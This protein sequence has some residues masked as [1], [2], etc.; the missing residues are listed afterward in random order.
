[1][2][3]QTKYFG[4]ISIEDKEIICFE[5]G[6]PGFLEEKE[7]IFLPL[8][9]GSIYYVM[10]SV[11]TAELAFIVTDPFVFFK[12][13]DFTLDDA[14]VDQLAIQKPTDVK[15]WTILTL[16]DPFE[17]T[18]ANLQGPIIIHSKNRQAKQVILN[19]PSYTT[20][21]RLFTNPAAVKG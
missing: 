12:S 8:T 1:M 7:F 11:R 15:V 14:T 21:H 10:Q 16:H 18:T 19:N 4:E 2:K 9:D 20:K 3:L 5:N 17:N 6:I 13:Y